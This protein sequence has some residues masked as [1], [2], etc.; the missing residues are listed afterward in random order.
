MTKNDVYQE[1]TDRIIAALEAGTVP[2]RKPWRTVNHGGPYSIR[3]GKPYRGIN[4][5]LLGLAGYSDPRWGT[6]KAIAEA[7]GQVRKG[8][9]GTRVI[10]WKPVPKKTGEVERDGYMLLRQYTVFNAE[11][12]DGLPPLDDSPVPEFEANER[13]AALADGYL[14]HGGPG[15]MH[16]YSGAYY[17]PATDIVRMPAHEDFAYRD[18]Y[19][20]TLFHELAH[21]TGHESRLDRLEPALFGTDPYARE[22]LVAEMTAAMLGGLAGLEQGDTDDSAA[23]IASWLKKLRDD[24]RLV[25]QAAAQAQKAADLIAGTT[26]EVEQENPQ[27]VAA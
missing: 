3:G 7:G 19:Y 11:Q 17:T 10:L 26:F 23:Y 9:K 15:L 4:I 2:W 18:A 14:S 12:A 1:V 13:A 21:S 20:R 8:E 27:A 6:Y 24:R 16:G 25:I 22:E 5:F